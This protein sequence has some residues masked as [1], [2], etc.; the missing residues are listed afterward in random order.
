[1]FVPSSILE[2]LG[3]LSPA[4]N[5]GFVTSPHYRRQQAWNR[6]ILCLLQKVCDTFQFAEKIFDGIQR[7]IGL[8]PTSISGLWRME[9]IACQPQLHGAPAFEVSHPHKVYWF[10]HRERD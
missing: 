6:S 1:M 9:Q 8:H 5:Q 10:A 4:L 3:A 2:V 7:Y